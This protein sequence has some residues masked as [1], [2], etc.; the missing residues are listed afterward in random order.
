MTARVVSP[1]GN[2][3]TGNGSEGAPYATV[4]KAASLSTSGDEIIVRGVLAN[5]VATISGT[6]STSNP[7]IIRPHDVD[8]GQLDGTWTYPTGAAVG[9]G[10]NGD[11]V[12]GGLASLTGTGIKWQ[13]PITR[14]RGRGISI[15]GSYIT[16]QN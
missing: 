10:P 3:T 2:D 9:S 14:S 8:G 11:F 12:Y 1:T 6:Y 15:A 7:L 13:V 16:I 5:Q 4:N